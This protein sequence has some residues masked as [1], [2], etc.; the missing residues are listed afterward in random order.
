MVLF[1]FPTGVA[2]INNLAGELAA[3]NNKKLE[4]NR[5]RL[6]EKKT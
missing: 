1:H 3:G 4:L 5:Y 6:T 2:G